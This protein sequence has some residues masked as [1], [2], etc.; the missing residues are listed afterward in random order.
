MASAAFSHTVSTTSRPTVILARA[1]TNNDPRRRKQVVR[2][3]EMI[4]DIFRQQTEVSFDLIEAQPETGTYLFDQLRQFR[5][6]NQTILLHI[7]GYA[8]GEYLHLE[9]G[10]GEES[11]SPKQFSRLLSRLPGLQMVFLNGCA[12]PELLEELLLM[13]IP[14]ILVT[15][16]TRSRK[17][18][19]EIAHTIYESLARGSS[20]EKAYESTQ[21]NHAHLFV[22]KRVFYNLEKDQLIWDGREKAFKRNQLEWGLYVLDENQDRLTADLAPASQIKKSPAQEE[23]GRKRRSRG[24][25]SAILAMGLMATM[26]LLLGQH[27]QIRQLWQSYQQDCQFESAENYKSLQFNFYEKGNCDHSDPFYNQAII[28]RMRQME[29]SFEHHLSTI[30]NCQPSLSGAERALRSCGADMAVWG[31][32]HFVDATRASL[33]F[34]YLYMGLPGTLHHGSREMEMPIH[35]F[36]SENDFIFSAVEDIVFWTMG[37]GYLERG[38][39]KQAI[40]AFEK[41]RKTDKTNYYTVDMQLARSYLQLKDYDKAKEHLDH[42]LTLVPEHV[43]SRYERGNIHL[44]FGNYAKARL[45]LDWVIDL[46]QDYADAY[47]SRGLLYVKT[48]QLDDALRDGR[49][50]LS[51]RP[52]EGRTHGLLTIIYAES[53]KPSQAIEH[54]ELGLQKGLEAQELFSSVPSLQQ[55]EANPEV[56]KI[57]VQYQ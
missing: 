42:L 2:E 5:F 38:E 25:V 8:T 48:G 43:E 16:E 53:N 49:Q 11:L 7:A 39:Y 17:Y 27:P 54:L 28:R 32:Y 52:E 10:W 46:K 22:Y 20:L 23:A 21:K 57:L 30:Q 44:R 14:A 40:E 31:S 29:G 4:A 50:L 12:S 18:S 26:L 9:G 1:N 35:L 41:M 24:I 45:D 13:D 15:S 3:C 56:Q 55:F 19:I 33:Q 6:Q 51:L 37:M 34:Q 47:Y 36:D